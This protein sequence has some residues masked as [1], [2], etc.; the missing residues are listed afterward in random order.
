MNS[1]DEQGRQAAETVREFYERLPYPR[2]VD[3]LDSYQRLWRDESRRRADFHLHWPAAPYREDRSILIAGCG[4]SQAAKHAMRWPESRVIGIDFSATSVQCSEALKR[5]HK[6]DNLE[7][8]QLPVERAAELG[9]GFDQIVCTGV[10]H[11]LADP[12]AGLA[13]LREVLNPDGAMHLMVYAPF[14]R[15]GI[16]LLQEFCQRV[17]IGPTDEGIRDLI[18]ALKALP[19]AHPLQPL[20]RD[21]DFRHEASLADAL[22]HPQDRAYSV[23]EVFDFIDGNGLTFGRWVRQAP[24]SIRC[25]VVAKLPQARR[26]AQL[27][28]TEQYAAVELFRGTMARH[29]LIAY[30]SDA[31]AR[32]RT[33][34]FAGDGWRDYVPIR[35]P[36][37][38]CIQERLPA[39]AAAVLINQTHTD[40]DLFLPVDATERHMFDAADGRATIGEIAKRTAGAARNESALDVARALFERLWWYDHVVFDASRPPLS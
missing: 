12:D 39:G 24:Y 26:M 14:G 23:P 40:T 7:L 2:P 32:R 3:S 27:S 25:G 8:R 30:R 36:D 15:T 35:T 18:T 34:D 31:C 10:L 29:S 21:P 33:I 6:L 22:L 4:T 16:Y 11:H 9:T 28:S 1:A 17:G 37:V 5:K 19:A 38:L 20:L 13:A